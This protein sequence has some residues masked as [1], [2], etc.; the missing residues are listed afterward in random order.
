M[1]ELLTMITS[2]SVFKLG[3]LTGRCGGTGPQIRAVGLHLPL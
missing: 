3:A 1:P 2:T